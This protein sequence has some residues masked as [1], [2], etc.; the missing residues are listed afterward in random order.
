MSNQ[1]NNNNLNPSPR[2]LSL[3]K[4]NAGGPPL[5]AVAQQPLPNAKQQTS[6]A[7]RLPIQQ[8]ENPI[9]SLD[10]YWWPVASVSAL[11]ETKPNPVQVLGQPLVLFKTNTVKKD[12]SNQYSSK[13]T[14]QGEHEWSCLQDACSHRFGPLSQGTIVRTVD[15]DEVHIECRNHKLTFDGSG[16]CRYVPEFQDKT[17]ADTRGVPSYPCQIAAGMVWVYTGIYDS[18]DSSVSTSSPKY[19][20]LPISSTLQT[21][22]DQFGDDACFVRDLNCGMELLLEHFVD[23]KLFAIHLSRFGRIGS[24]SSGTIQNSIANAYGNY[25]RYCPATIGTTPI[26]PILVWTTTIGAVACQKWSTWCSDNYHQ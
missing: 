11:D 22:Y 25:T 2:Q 19:T 5:P 20:D 4:T 26:D 21:W 10:Q 1:D 14:N 7:Q 15:T 13:H 3:I 17:C 18:D 12:D 23:R 6:S 8:L 16:V 9:R 24:I